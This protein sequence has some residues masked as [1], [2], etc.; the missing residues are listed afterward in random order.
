MNNYQRICSILL[1][2]NHLWIGTGSGY[3]HIYSIYLKQTI[4]EKKT[5]NDINIEENFFLES[6]L[7]ESKNYPNESIKMLNTNEDSNSQYDNIND[8]FLNENENQGTLFETMNSFLRSNLSDVKE[9]E[10]STD[11]EIFDFDFNNTSLKKLEIIEDSVHMNEEEPTALEYNFLTSSLKNFKSDHSINL[12]QKENAI[13]FFFK[14]NRPQT[15]E[16][17]EFSSCNTISTIGDVKEWYSTNSVIE[18]SNKYI[19]YIECNR[20]DSVVSRLP[21]EELKNYNL[22]KAYLSSLDHSYEIYLKNLNNSMPELNW[23]KKMSKKAIEVVQNS[24]LK[25]TNEQP[26]NYDH[27]NEI[28]SYNDESSRLVS[29]KKHLYKIAYDLN[30]SLINL[31]SYIT[32]NEIESNDTFLAYLKNSQDSLN[33]KKLKNLTKQFFVDIKNED[34]SSHLV[35][36]SNKAGLFNHSCLND[37]ILNGSNRANLQITSADDKNL[38]PD[39]IDNDKERSETTDE[40]NEMSFFDLIDDSADLS[41]PL[42]TVVNNKNEIE[43]FDLELV[44]RAK[45]SD[46]PIRCIQMHK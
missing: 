43:I 36:E 35:N 11:S 28:S 14:T 22:I 4:L 40:K 38:I 41:H 23:S 37:N 29:V 2:D 26:Y 32:E 6:I 17:N 8:Q 10:E 25:F 19:E 39:R 5:V 9:E 3:I 13:S 34:L 7:T 30:K 33:E 45:C 1:L 20:L 42:R 12:K 27:L 16:E 46:Q 31:K 15:G 44:L 24:L 18:I 21:E